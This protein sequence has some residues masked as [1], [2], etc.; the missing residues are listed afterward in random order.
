MNLPVSSAGQL[1]VAIWEDPSTFKTLLL[2]DS[3]YNIYRV[4]VTNISNP[5]HHSSTSLNLSG[6][7]GITGGVFD[8]YGNTSFWTAG[9][10]VYR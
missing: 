5:V 4:D 10:T 8:P 7:V 9:S 1:T 2:G 6:G 3:E